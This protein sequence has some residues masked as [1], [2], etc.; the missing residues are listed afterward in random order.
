VLDR[1]PFK[2]IVAAD[3]E[4]EFGGHKSLEDA[5]RSGQR[6]RP[7]C[8]VLKDL[9]TAQVWEW[10]RGE[11]WTPPFPIDCLVAYYAS[12]ELGCFKALNLPAPPYVLDLFTEFRARTNGRNIPNG[13]SL[14]GA[15]TYFGID[16]IDA[17]EKQDL[18][19][20]ILSGGPYSNE[21][22][23]A[24]VAY[25]ATDTL[26]CA[27]QLL[28][29]MLPR[30]DLPRALLRGRFMKAAAIVEWNG[31]PID[32]TTLELL[33]RYWTD[34]QDDLIAAIDKD[35]GVFEGR[36]FKIERWERW[37]AAH[38]IPW[39]RLASGRLDL[40]DDTFRQMARA[41]PAVAPMREL[42]SALSEMRLADL[43]VGS[44]G[45]NRTILSVF[46]ARSGRCAPSNTKYIF[47]PSV[48]LRSLIQSRP[49]YGIA[50]IDWEQQEL[51]IAAVRS[52]DQAMLS[53]YLSGDPYLEFAKQAGAI[54]P[55]AT[56]ASHPSQR[57][58]FKT[59]ALGVIY[60]MEAESLAQRIGQPTIVGRDLMRAHRETYRQFWRWSDAVVDHA[61]LTGSLHTAFGW[62]IYV[63]EGFNP[64][65]LRNFVM[66]ADGSE[67][68]RLG[69]CF[70]VEQD[71]EVC[72]LIHDAV[73]I[74]APLDR[75]DEDIKR[76][77]ACMAKASR[78][79]LDGFELRTDVNIVRHPDRYHD[80]RGRLMWDRVMRLIAAREAVRQGV[81]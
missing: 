44:D 69:T 43:A 74:C 31:T 57:E 15:L 37:L 77:R 52:G 26:A 39:P 42:R 68:L 61:V 49:G 17:A 54:P 62:P 29:A 64:R 78:I 33:R 55:D 3:F 45:R 18:R 28:P 16:G 7:V 35:Y 30:I 20:R 24:Y 58:L 38:G 79:V 71:I 5:S 11:P 2:H 6:P 36:T 80:P 8:A 56:K 40:S 9:R 65:S 22:M 25:C 41:Y 1:L 53:A 46:R 72:A 76:M 50:Y 21:D 19:L 12:A 73:L 60:G 75:L 32:V 70:A 13:A 10:R 14:L 27:D 23:N 67:L 66:Q 81:A 47:G 4:F 48:W 51:G 34:I 63:G 59:C